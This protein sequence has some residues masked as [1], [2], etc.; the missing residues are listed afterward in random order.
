MNVVYQASFLP[1]TAQG[2]VETNQAPKNE[3]NGSILADIQKE[4]SDDLDE[5]IVVPHLTTEQILADTEKLDIDTLIF[6]VKR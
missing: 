4:I 6:S 3:R 1:A 2:Q 5:E